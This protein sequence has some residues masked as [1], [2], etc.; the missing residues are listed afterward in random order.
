MYAYCRD[1]LHMSEAAAY[2]RTSAARAARQFPIIFDMI[3]R[4][5]IHLSGVA[6]LAKPLTEGNHKELLGAAKHQTKHRI[7]ELVK[8]WFPSPDATSSVRKLPQQRE[9]V[10]TGQMTLAGG[11]K[12]DVG[13]PGSTEPTPAKPPMAAPHRSMIAPTGPE[14][15]RIQFAVGKDLRDKLLEAQALLRHQVPDGDISEIFERGL[16]LLLRDVKKKRFGVGSR[17]KKNASRV[18]SSEKDIALGQKCEGADLAPGQKFEPAATRQKVPGSR[19]IPNEVKRA[20]FERDGGRCSFVGADGKRCDETAF[21]ELHHDEAHAKGGQNTVENITLLC[22]PHNLYAAE[23]EFGATQIAD[24]VGKSRE[25]NIRKTPLL[26]PLPVRE[27]R[28]VWYSVWGPSELNSVVSCAL[29]TS[30]CSQGSTEPA[31]YSSR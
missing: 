20:V 8:E 16:D 6:V 12:S 17:P 4:G 1:R 15:F 2:E 21:L 30:R 26:S 28:L 19:H 9:Q 24:K 18:A 29:W 27:R 31:G 11:N 10:V 14:R 5:D 25:E 3:A 23:Q 13:S 7:E 22:R